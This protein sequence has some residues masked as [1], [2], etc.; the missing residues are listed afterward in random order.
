MS[1]TWVMLHD[2]S[3]KFVSV[4]VRF[5]PRFLAGPG[6][7]NFFRNNSSDPIFLSST[8]ILSFSP[9]ITEVRRFSWI[10]KLLR[11]IYDH[12]WQLF[13]VTID[14]FWPWFETTFYEI[15]WHKWLTM[16]IIIMIMVVSDVEGV[17]LLHHPPLSIVLQFQFYVL[18]ERKKRR[19]QIQRHIARYNSKTHLRNQK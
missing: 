4:L 5:G 11:P 15:S 8:L 13:L 10:V 9:E 12:F 17:L 1:P 19:N 18:F 3:L 14:Q 6:F 2:C 16:L 7:L